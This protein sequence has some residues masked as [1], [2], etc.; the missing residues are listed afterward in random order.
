MDFSLYKWEITSDLQQKIIKLEAVKLVFEKLKINPQVEENLRK[1]ALLK[2]AV[3]SARIE[4]FTDTVNAPKL[5]SQNLVRAYNFIRSLKAPKNLAL[6]F[7]KSIHRSVLANISGSAGRWRGEAW[8]IFNEA[9]MVIHTGWP[10]HELSE[11]MPR[12]I[13]YINNLKDHPVI[14]AAVAQFVFEKIHPFADGNGRAGRLVSAFLLAKY[15]YGFRGL[16]PFEQ[17]IDEH[18]DSYYYSLQPSHRVNV[19]IEYF[20]EALTS[21]AEMTID[22]LSNVGEAESSVILPPRR[23]EIIQVIRDHPYSSLDTIHRRFIN[24]NIKTLSYDIAQLTKLKYIKKV[25]STRGAVY[26]AC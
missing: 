15:N 13:K 11:V 17:Y 5:E 26:V 20:L 25:G 6:E 14:K 16:A 18:R 10:H 8:A 12:Y 1:T 4:G 2:S 19:F 3:H 21:Q 9:G 24:I 23:Q 7:V 22:Q